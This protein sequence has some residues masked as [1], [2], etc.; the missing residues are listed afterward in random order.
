MVTATIGAVFPINNAKLYVPVVIL[1]I[2]DN[3]TFLRNIK[4]EFKRTISWNKYRSEIT[5]YKKNNN[6]DYLIDPRFRNINRFFVLSFKNGYDDPTRY[7]FDDYYMPFTEIIDFNALIDNDP[8]F[9]Q[10]VKNKQKAYGKLTEMS[11][12]YDYSTG[13]LLDCLS[14]QKYYKPIG[15]DLSRQTN[16]RIPQQINFIAKLEEDDGATTFF[17]CEKQQKTILNFSLNLLIVIE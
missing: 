14:H 8:F 16:T 2:N 9:D 6:S 13:N 4:Q 12:N 17:I 3:I 10:P 11:K 7:S 5:T 1:S 15:T